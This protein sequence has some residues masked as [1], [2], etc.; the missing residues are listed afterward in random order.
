MKLNSSVRLHLINPVEIC[1]DQIL[2]YIIH[3]MTDPE[4]NSFETSGLECLSVLL[5]SWSQTILYKSISKSNK[6]F[7]QALALDWN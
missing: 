3:L 4:G 5:Y 6:I 1:G 2:S 7:I